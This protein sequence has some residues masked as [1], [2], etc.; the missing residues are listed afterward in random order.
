MLV[1]TDLG[2]AEISAMAGF[3]SISHMNHL[4]RAAC[5]MTPSEYRRR[6]RRI[7]IP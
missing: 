5:G 7:V 4:F 6:N 1:D 3:E 2:V